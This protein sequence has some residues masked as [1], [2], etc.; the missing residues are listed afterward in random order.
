M[1]DKVRNLRDVNEQP[2]EDVVDALEHALELARFG[3]LRSVAI[4]G[5]L[6]GHRTYTNFATGDL[7][8]SIG[9]VSFVHHTLC[10]RK[11]D[12]PA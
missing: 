4:V 2:D 9:Y 3:E 1:T 5:S 8:E 7:T 6:T 10:A 12:L 11:R